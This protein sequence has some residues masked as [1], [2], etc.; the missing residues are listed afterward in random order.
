MNTVFQVGIQYP[1]CWASYSAVVVCDETTSVLPSV[2]KI[3]PSGCA[4][5]A[6]LKE[7]SHECLEYQTMDTA[8]SD[9]VW[10]GVNTVHDDL[11][12][13]SLKGRLSEGRRL[14]DVALDGCPRWGLDLVERLRYVGGLLT[15]P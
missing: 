14:S 7:M 1:H 3:H 9:R 8:Y 11:I 12:E 4:E 2:I 15:R 6:S 5:Y 10:V 13:G